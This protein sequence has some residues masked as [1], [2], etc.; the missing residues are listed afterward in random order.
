[1]N[2][3][4]AKARF[5]PKDHRSKG[6]PQGRGGGHKPAWR[7]RERPDGPA[8]LYGWHTVTA[9]LANPKRKIRK[10][11]LTENAAR[12]LA[13]ENIDTRVPPEMVRPSQ[14]D[15]R[16][17]PDAVH[18]GLL[19]EADP[20]PSPSIETLEREGIVL[21]LD[22]ITDPHNVGAIL[23]SASAFD[24]KAI[25]TTARHSPEATGVLAKSAS[26]ALELV[27]FVTVQNLARALTALN[28]RGFMTVGLDSE[29]SENLADVTLEAPLALVLGA[30]G[31][32]LRQLTR[33]TCSVVARL[34]MPGAIKS[35]N[36]SNAAVLA[37][38]IGAT[39]LGL[40]R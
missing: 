12:R 21:V 22:Q 34:D 2:D 23:R 5:R 39:R 33:E 13:E 37:L 8:I 28:E 6:G 18:Q 38:Y 25:V 35:L 30:E 24:V 14:I 1:M 27:P 3:R 19:A 9:A 26:G 10:L 20:L 11:F 36:V 32:G 40:M 15:Q 31:K 29:G 4:D 17:G 16:L 7:E